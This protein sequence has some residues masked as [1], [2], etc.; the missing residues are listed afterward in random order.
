MSS[1]HHSLEAS[2]NVMIDL[3]VRPYGQNDYVWMNE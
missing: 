3:R 2:L 1:N